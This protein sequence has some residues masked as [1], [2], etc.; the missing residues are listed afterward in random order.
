L[1]VA[2]WGEPLFSIV[3]ISFLHPGTALLSPLAISNHSQPDILDMGRPPARQCEM[4]HTHFVFL[5]F[6]PTQ[7]FPQPL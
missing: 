4:H 1:E 6:A 3:V 2:V 7:G 5:A